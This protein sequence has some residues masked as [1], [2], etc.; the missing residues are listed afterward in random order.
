MRPVLN[1]PRRAAA[2]VASTVAYLCGKVEAPD[3]STIVQVVSVHCRH[4]ACT[5]TAIVFKHP[6]GQQHARRE[7]D[8]R[9]RCPW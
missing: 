2:G 8:I 5:V 1:C 7:E 3:Q 6:G 9:K 4:R